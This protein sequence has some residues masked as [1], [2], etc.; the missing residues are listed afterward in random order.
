MKSQEVSTLASVVIAI[1]TFIGVG[2]AIAYY[3]KEIIK[4]SG[5]FIVLVE[6]IYLLF[7]VIILLLIKRNLN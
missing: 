2:A 4:E 1:P 3:L 7:T 5:F 6:I